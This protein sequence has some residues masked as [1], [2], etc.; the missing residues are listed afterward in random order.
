MLP[1]SVNLPACM[2]S[3][4]KPSPI[5]AESRE[6]QLDRLLIA[7]DAT[8]PLSRYAFEPALKQIETRWAAAQRKKPSR[9]L[10]R[11]Y[12]EAITKVLALSYMIG[13]DFFAAEIEKARW[14]RLN[15]DA[16]DSKLHDIMEMHEH[17]R[18]PTDVDAELTKR[19]LDIDHWFKTSGEV[20][21]KRAVRKEIVEPFLEMMVGRETESSRKEVF[22]AL[23]DWI[24]VE[25]KFRPSNASINTIAR[26]LDARA[27]LSGS[28]ATQQTEN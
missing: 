11:Q 20:Y 13:P 9:K 17:E 19:G 26:E 8:D 21:R 6:Q 4:T 12:R 1:N 15:P 14:S 2:T 7:M 23:F 22:D 18:E 27:S 16:D 25:K 5:K 3:H 28:D 24:G 10:V